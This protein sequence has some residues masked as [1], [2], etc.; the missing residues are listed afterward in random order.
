MAKLVPKSREAAP[1][2]IVATLRIAEL[3]ADHKA[4]NIK[5]Y[6]VRG[7]T[8]IADVFVLCS[9]SSEPQLRAVYNA[10]REGMKEAGTAP[11]R[12][13][14]S[15]SGAWLILDYGHTVFH[16][17]RT[18]ARAFYDLDGLW[19]DAPEIELEL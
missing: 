9:A 6:D 10:V 12:S 16:V 13:E 7:L 2:F 3:A 15:V 5:A 14:G 17:F 19:G 1:D 4:Q 18:E 11:L 8:V